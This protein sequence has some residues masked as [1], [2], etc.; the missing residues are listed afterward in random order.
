MRK[1]NIA[2]LL[3]NHAEELTDDIVNLEDIRS[4]WERTGVTVCYCSRREEF[5]APFAETLAAAA[6]AHPEYRIPDDAALRKIQTAL[7]ELKKK[8]I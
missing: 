4:E 6:K 7:Y 3:V 8:R 5:V 1:I 2:P